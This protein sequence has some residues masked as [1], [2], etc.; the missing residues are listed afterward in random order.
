MNDGSMMEFYKEGNLL[1]YKTNN[2]I[3]GGLAYSGN[4]TFIGGVNDTEAIF[5]LLPQG[6]AN[7]RFRFSRRRELKL[8]GSKIYSY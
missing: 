2:Q 5:E 4:N 3:W 1:F 7:L 6:K 8:E